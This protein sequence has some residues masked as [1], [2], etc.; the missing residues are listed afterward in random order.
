MKVQ[1]TRRS[2]ARFEYFSQCQ[3]TLRLPAVPLDPDGYTAAECFHV[4][5]T[6]GKTLPCREP[7]LFARALNGKEQHGLNVTHVAEDYIGRIVFAKDLK[8]W[9]PEWVRKDILGR[10]GQ[11]AMQTIGYVPTFVKIGE[12][13]STMGIPSDLMTS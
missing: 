11:L 13:F 3:D 6:F 7:E 2:L 5:E 1:P 12:D 8:E 4:S 10:A 9:F